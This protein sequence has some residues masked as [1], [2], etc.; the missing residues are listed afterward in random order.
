MADNKN[1]LEQVPTPVW[2]GLF[3]L[4][5]ANSLWSD[6]KQAARELGKKTGEALDE[7]QRSKDYLITLPEFKSS[8]FDALKGRRYKL[9]TA[10]SAERLAQALADAKGFFNDNEELLFSTIA[11]INYR[12]QLAQVAGVFTKKTGKNLGSYIVSFTNTNERHRIEKLIQ[13]METGLL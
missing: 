1:F 11:K 6:A 13:Q 9:F 2:I 3:G 10:E 8:F 5:A 7:V 4:I 12:T